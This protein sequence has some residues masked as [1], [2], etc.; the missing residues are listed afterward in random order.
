[1]L[2]VGADWKINYDEGHQWNG[3]HYFGA[4][5]ESL[6]KLFSD[7]GYF[8]VAC[9]PHTGA[10]AFFVRNEYR[11][12]FADVPDKIEDIYVSPFYN[13]DNKFTH[14]ISPEFIKSITF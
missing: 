12:L 14:R 5:L 8:L 13:L 11:H 10:N 4:S 9:N 1:M 7:F 6:S 3:D 2:P